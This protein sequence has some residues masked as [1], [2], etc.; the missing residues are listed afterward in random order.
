LQIADQ[1]Q[2][3]DLYLNRAF[4]DLKLISNPTSAI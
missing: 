2:I 3:A 1:L 4:R